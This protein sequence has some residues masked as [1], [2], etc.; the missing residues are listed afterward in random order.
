MVYRPLHTEMRQWSILNW[1]NLFTEY[2]NHC[3]LAQ[4]N[5][6]LPFHTNFTSR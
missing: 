1:Q 2:V 6:N 4:G 3:R 5:G